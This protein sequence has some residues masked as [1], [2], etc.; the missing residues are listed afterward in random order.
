[1]NWL[2]RDTPLGDLEILEVYVEYDGPRVFAC[3]SLTDQ[4]YIAGWAEEGEDRDL[5]LYLPVSRSR[6]KMI[7]SGGFALKEAFTRAEGIVYLATLFHDSTLADEM[8]ALSPGR[9]QDDWLPEDG[10][11]LELETPTHVAA[12]SLADLHRQAIQEGRTRFRIE[13]SDDSVMRTES[14]TRRVAGILNASQNVLDNFGLVELEVNPLQDGRFSRLVEKRMET[15]VLG[16]AAASF[17]IELGSTDGLDLLGDSPIARVSARL[18]DLLSVKLSADELWTRLADLK[19][20]AA[21]SFRS[22][23]NELASFNS[24]VTLASASAQG[25]HQQT[26]SAGQIMDLRALLKMIVPDVIRQVSGR[27]VL[28]SG[29]NDR[30]TFGLR[31]RND[32][33]TY[34]GR[35][36]E[37]AIAQVAHAELGRTYDVRLSEYAQHDKGAGQLRLKYVLEQ[38]SPAEDD[39]PVET[40][41]TVLNAQQGLPLWS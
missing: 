20:R 17:V 22:F 19:P 15:G 32:D 16:L 25:L 1:M 24:A 3:T 38:L 11:R 21:K 33:A 29:D 23:V 5:W 37:S 7:R 27:M 31:D 4:L 30:R 2:P 9:L 10:Y 26:L 40:I 34:E 6:L 35:I 39:A 18:V 36:G 41:F 28:F 8:L 12:V 13:I 14:S